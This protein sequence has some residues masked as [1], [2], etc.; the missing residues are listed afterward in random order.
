[1][2]SDRDGAGRAR[3]AYPSRLDL[4]LWL[5]RPAEEHAERRVLPA[6][7]REAGSLHPADGTD[8][9]DAAG[10]KRGRERVA[11]QTRDP[12]ALD[13]RRGKESGHVLGPVDRM[14]ADGPQ[15]RGRA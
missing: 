9:R 8:A 10:T 1:M 2:R 12:D 15:P 6:R 3:R 11:L 5:A 13:R 7:P 4:E 14:D